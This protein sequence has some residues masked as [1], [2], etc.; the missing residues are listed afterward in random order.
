MACFFD[1]KHA[2]DVVWHRKLLQKI[3]NLGYTGNF[4]LYVRNFLQRTMQVK[5]QNTLSK[6]HSIDCGVPQGTCLAPT[7]FNIM[8]AD[9]PAYL[10]KNHKNKSPFPLQLSQFADDIAIWQAIKTN[11]PT[12]KLIR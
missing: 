12:T 10:E 5:I 6:Y 4:Y 7:L 3:K 11:P 1:V 2:F 8:L 9:L